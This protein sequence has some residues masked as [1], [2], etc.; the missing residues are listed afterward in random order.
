MLK[1]RIIGVVLIK[2]GIAVQSIGFERFLPIGKPTIAINFLDNWGIDEIVVLDITASKYNR[3][4]GASDIASYSMECLVPLAVG[5][6]IT[7]VGQVREIVQA[8]ADKVVINA[9]LL[10]DRGILSRGSNAF[11]QQCMVA[12]VN[13]LKTDEGKYKLYDHTAETLSDQDVFRFITS[14]QEAGAGEILLNAVHCD[15]KK[16]GYDLELIHRVAK[17]LTIPLIALGGAGHSKDLLFAL[18]AGAD[19]VAVGNLFHFSEHSVI[20]AKS[21]LNESG[22]NVRLDGEMKYQ[23]IGFGNSSRINC[24]T[25]A[26][27]DALRFQHIAEEVI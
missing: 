17:N 7:S 22:V 27:L 21:Y 10:K 8:G 18:D 26:E 14:L 6:G 19:A 20:T 5:G 24:R 3:I 1:S 15:G 12:S 25:E 16:L 2:D 11:G 4:I 23:G 9:A 13:V